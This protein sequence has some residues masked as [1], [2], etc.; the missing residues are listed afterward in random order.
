M[1]SGCLRRT[2]I[3]IAP[4]KLSG[5]RVFEIVVSLTRPPILHFA[6]ALLLYSCR[7]SLTPAYL[8]GRRAMVSFLVSPEVTWRAFACSLELVFV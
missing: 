5:Q 3:A 2:A 6:D 8:A 1:S 4:A 7:E